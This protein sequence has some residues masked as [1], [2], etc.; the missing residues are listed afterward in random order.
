[1]RPLSGSKDVR[2]WNL[3]Q[4]GPK[5][6]KIPTDGVGPGEIG[7]FQPEMGLEQSAPGTEIRELIL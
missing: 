3:S 4:F 2:L 7:G 1:M 6:G 5:P